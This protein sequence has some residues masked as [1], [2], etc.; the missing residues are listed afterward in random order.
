M[1][2]ATALMACSKK[3]ST[4]GAGAGATVPD[5]PTFTVGKIDVDGTNALVPPALKDKIV[6]DKRA[7]AVKRG[8][9]TTTFTVAAPK[10]WKQ[11]MDAF[12]DLKADD[13]GGFFSAFRVGT[14]C[15]GSCEPKDWE[16]V[17]DKATFAA[18]PEGR[19]GREGRQGRGH[20]HADRDRHE[21]HEGHA[22]D[23]RGGRPATTTTICAK[24][25]STR[26]SPTRRPRSRR[27]AA[28]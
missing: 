4:E 23:S 18:V 11:D 20:A 13:K 1:L 8:H 10:N 15:D 7:I 27:R 5:G 12:A 2:A 28:R 25:R 14:N 24:R 22:R 16:K 17:A 6:F 26:R 9:A 21:Q 3:D 19:D